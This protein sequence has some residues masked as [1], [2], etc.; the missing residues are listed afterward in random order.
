MGA[1]LVTFGLTYPFA[2]LPLRRV[3]GFIPGVQALIAAT[4]FITAV[5]LYGQYAVA[6][7][8]ALVVLASGY[9]F[10][11]LIVLAQT[12]TFPGAFSPSGILGA[13]PQTAA[14]L[15]FVWHLGF[16]AAVVGYALKR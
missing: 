4:D 12:L 16:P 15:Y 14:W 6:R 2:L 7:S 1:I 11:A 8:R 3:D 9:L 13:G 5:L 10:A